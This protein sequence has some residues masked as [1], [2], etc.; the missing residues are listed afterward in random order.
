[1]SIENLRRHSRYVVMQKMEKPDFLFPPY[2]MFW[3]SHPSGRGMGGSPLRGCL[4]CKGQG[5]FIADCK[6]KRQK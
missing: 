1:M 2:P 5:H 4:L 3:F 6:I